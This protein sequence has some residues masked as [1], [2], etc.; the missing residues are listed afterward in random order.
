MYANNEGGT[1]GG[2][3]GGRELSPPAALQ[4][5]NIPAGTNSLKY[6]PSMATPSGVN[7]VVSAM[8]ADGNAWAMN[9]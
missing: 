1:D 7:A 2:K 9:P 6:D 4:E 5:Q 3:Q 8:Y